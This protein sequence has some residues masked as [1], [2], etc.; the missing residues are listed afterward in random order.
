MHH[1][2]ASPESRI[3]NNDSGQL[4]R[5]V[6]ANWLLHTVLEMWLSST[7]FTRNMQS[8]TTSIFFVLS[9]LHCVVSDIAIFV[10]KRDIKLQLTLHCESL[11]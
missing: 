4:N 7:A 9:T 10:L 5:I 1:Y 2:L 6:A 11:L 3:A 8:G